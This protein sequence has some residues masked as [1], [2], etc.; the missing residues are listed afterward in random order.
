MPRDRTGSQANPSGV[1]RVDGLPRRNPGWHIGDAPAWR[2]GPFL[3][4]ARLLSVS[5]QL[6]IV[7]TGLC[8]ALA[9]VAAP[10]RA[11]IKVGHGRGVA[12]VRARVPQM[13]WVS[14]A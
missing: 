5:Q 4:P 11:R 12:A 7:F 8:N 3:Y 10:A 13:P 1:P 9:V 6:R 14:A 2:D